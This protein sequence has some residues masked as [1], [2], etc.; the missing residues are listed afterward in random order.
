MI[1]SNLKLIDVSFQ[2]LLHA[3]GLSL[4]LGFGFKRGLHGV[5]GALVVLAG[6]FE[7]L[8]LLLDAA[9]DFLADLRQFQLS[10]QNLVL[11]LFQGSFGFLQSSL[12]FVLFG[13]QTL[14]RLLD[15]VDVA[16]TLA[17]L[18]QQILDFISQVLVLTADSLKLLLAFFVGTLETEQFGGVVAAFLLGSI[19]L[20]SQIVDLELPFSN[21]LVEGLLLLLGSVG[22]G[23]GTVDLE[24]QILD[25]G[26]Q[27]LLGLLQSDT[28]LVERLDGFLGFGK[29]GLEFPLGFLELLGAGNTLGLVLGTPQLGF[30]VGLAELALDVSLAFGFLLNLLAQAVEVVLQVAELAEQGGAFAGFFVGETLGVLQLLGERDLDLAELRDL[31]FG[32]L[33]LA[34]QVGVFDRQLLLGGIEVVQGAVGFIQLALD[35]VQSVLQLLGN[36]L[37]GSLFYF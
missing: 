18:V 30:G 14:A 9:V 12:E 34:E 3:Q 29:A 35:F 33:Q 19:Q 1:Q 6:V 11:F 7:L 24:L 15:L 36:L 27:T 16:A 13:F 8:F 17:D 5:Q 28:L 25:L 26:G 20:G 10:A 32:I 22:N 23:G 2:L 37:L 4:T 21:D 31:G